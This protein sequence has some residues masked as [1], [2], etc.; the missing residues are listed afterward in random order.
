MTSRQLEEGDVVN[1]PPSPLSIVLLKSTA[2]KKQCLKTGSGKLKHFR[3]L[4]KYSV[5][6][7]SESKFRQKH[8][9]NKFVQC[10]THTH[11]HSIKW[12][13]LQDL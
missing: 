6:P 4:R 9:Q 13:T 12:K 11:M 10:H 7:A 8:F 1:I 2:K 5:I 3:V